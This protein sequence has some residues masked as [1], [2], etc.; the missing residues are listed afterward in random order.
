MT[1]SQKRF[2]EKLSPGQRAMG[3]VKS[4]RDYGAMVSVGMVS[5][6]LHNRNIRWG[7]VERPEDHLRLGQKIEVVVLEVDKE[8]HRFSVGLKQLTP[9]PWEAFLQR[10]RPGDSI[11]G[12]VVAIR[13]YG[14]ILEIIPGVTALLLAS[15]TPESLNQ[16]YEVIIKD[17]D[18][19]KRRMTVEL[20]A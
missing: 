14:M 8:K 5:G 1:D 9:D 4:F 15:G 7:K 2:I 12:N 6:L 19:K 3:V 11:A 18:P 16:S 20:P 10:H 13:P 17:L